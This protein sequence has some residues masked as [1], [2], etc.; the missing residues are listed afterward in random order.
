MCVLFGVSCPDGGTV[1]REYTVLAT[2][3]LEPVKDCWYLVIS[4]VSKC[5]GSPIS[6][7]EYQSCDGFWIVP[8]VIYKYYSFIFYVFF[9][10]SYFIQVVTRHLRD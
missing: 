3:Y 10:I 8:S 9:C 2:E 5:H 4:F 7:T 6:G 1:D